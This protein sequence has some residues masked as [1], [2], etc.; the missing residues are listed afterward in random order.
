MKI[1]VYVL[2]ITIICIAIADRRIGKRQPISTAISPRE[3]YRHY[4]LVILLV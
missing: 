2:I 3:K 4:K 1:L